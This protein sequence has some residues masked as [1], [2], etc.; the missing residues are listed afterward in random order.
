MQWL[1]N[2][3][4]FT[5]HKKFMTHLPFAHVKVRFEYRKQIL[6]M[7]ALMAMLAFDTVITNEI[8]M[9]LLL[10]KAFY[11]LTVAFPV[12]KIM[13]PRQ[14]KAYFFMPWY[15]INYLRCQ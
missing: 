3:T 2:L 11:T 12:N 5:S 7:C 8:L 15:S 6:L 4:S 9:T 13:S 10:E 1:C 14:M